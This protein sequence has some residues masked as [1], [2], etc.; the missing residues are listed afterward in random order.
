MDL[1]PPDGNCIVAADG[2]IVWSDD[3]FNEWFLFRGIAPGTKI[4]QLFPGERDIFRIGAVFEDTDRLGK[5][6]YFTMENK[7]VA[8]PGGDKVSDEI[9]IR[10]I[11]LR[12]VLTEISRLSSL[13]KTPNE[14]F[15]KVLW[16]LRDTT[17]YLAFAGYIARNDSI[18][19]VASKGW[20]E[21]L[22]SYISVQDIAPDT[23]SLAG[24]TAYHRQQIVM[25]MKD[26]KLR[27]DVKSAITKLGG[28][29]I[30]VTPL[31]DHDRIVGVLTVINDKVL[32]PA[33]SEVLQLIC[34][35]VAVAL[36]LK[37]QEERAVEK[38]DDAILYANLIEHTMKDNSLFMRVSEKSGLAHEAEKVLK[39][40]ADAAEG[41]LSPL[42]K[43]LNNGIVPEK[44]PVKDAMDQAIMRARAM[45]ITMNKKVSF[46]VSGLDQLQVSP[47]FK[48]AF[49]EVLKNSIVHSTASEVEADIRI[50]KERTGAYHIVIS[51]NGP[52]IRD[53]FKSE[54]FR[55]RKDNMKN[56]E[57]MGLYLVKRIA[58]KF[59]GRVWVED[60][61]HGDHKKGASVVITMPPV[62]H[63]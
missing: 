25:A 27:T 21:K 15:E 56:P 2:T 6:R 19:L 3:V 53:E 26:Y 58:N 61:V 5:K 22:K 45:A 9:R 46:K 23:M 55:P 20:T 31:V 7:P 59:G 14:L 42:L 36:S 11:T 49:Y 48:Y 16:L 17:H 18:E 41:A 32:T 35:Q 60:R 37:L 4:G 29:Y 34:N 10:K 43:A 30:V 50:S 57:G 44:I 1:I 51:D 63:E 62:K 54:V 12:K 38:E 52:G 39:G 24:R 13:A 33:D 8:S 28:E 40:T 47:L